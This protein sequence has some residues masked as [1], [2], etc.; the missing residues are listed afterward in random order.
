MAQ[1]HRSE[2]AGPDLLT[3]PTGSRSISRAMAEPDKIT[4]APY[5]YRDNFLRL[6]GGPRASID[7]GEGE[8]L[9]EHDASSERRAS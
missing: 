7:P 3:S 5:Y 9:R 2:T 8:T 6:C 1:G 4:L